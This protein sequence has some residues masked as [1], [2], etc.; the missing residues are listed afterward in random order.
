VILKADRLSDLLGEG[1]DGAAA[2]P[3]VIVPTPDLET[4]RK[5]GTASVDLR[6][7][8]WFLQARQAR[9]AF[10]K[11]GDQSETREPVT[12]SYVPFGGSFILHP[13]SFVL[14]MTLEWISL[15]ADLA[16][17]VIGKSSWG[18]YGLIIATATGVHPGYKGCLTLELTN[19]GEIPIEIKPGVSICQLFIHRL[20]SAAA[21]VSISDFGGLRRPTLRPIRPDPF[22]EKLAHAYQ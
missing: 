9:T 14:A 2:D 10:L 8:T 4:L 22:A 1:R 15:P 7:G 21:E 20:E 17:Y 16:A 11:L 12:T 5:Q 3:L 19:V 18:R 13:Q 6:L